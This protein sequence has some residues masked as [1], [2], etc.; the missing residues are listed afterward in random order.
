MRNNVT[1]HAPGERF[2]RLTVLREDPQAYPDRKVR[3]VCQ[4]DCGTVKSI[5]GRYLRSGDTR[6]CGCWGDENRRRPEPRTLKHGLAGGTSDGRPPEYH[7]WV[8]MRQRCRDTNDRSYH[9]YGGRGI[10]VCSEWNDFA[11]FYRDMGPRPTP[12]HSIDRIDNDGPYSPGNCRWATSAEQANNRRTTR[13]LTHEGETL[14]LAEWS[15]VTGI[16]A[17]TLYNRIWS[18]WPPSRA[19]TEPPNQ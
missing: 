2:G 18:G 7:V 9:R 13:R 16:K 19:L 4:C 6:S 1:K 12:R 10:V 3:W 15:K 8:I 5:N 17:T 11:V 14:T